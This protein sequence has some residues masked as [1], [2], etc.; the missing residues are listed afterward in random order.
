[1]RF[2]KLLALVLALVLVMS[3][4]SVA[5]ADMKKGKVSGNKYTSPDGIS[6][7]VPKGFSLAL[8]QNKKEGFFRIVLGGKA[9]ARGFGPAILVDIVPGTKDMESYT[10]RH[11]LQ[12]IEKYPIANGDKYTDSYI[13]S[14]KLTEEYDSPTRENLVVFRL[15]RFSQARV[16][17]SYSFCY[18]T[19]KYLVRASYLCFGAQRTLTNDVP[20]FL[21]LYNSLVVP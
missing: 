21:D 5:A 17:F 13:I 16:A 7:I 4:F 8:Q 6:F 14:D 11:L 15:N 9:D 1:M 2:R 18:S 12:D 19:D 10:G 20:L 3:V